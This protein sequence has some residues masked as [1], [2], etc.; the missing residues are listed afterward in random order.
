MKIIKFVG[1]SINGITKLYI[2]GIIESKKA[3]LIT[4]CNNDSNAL[5]RITDI[6]RQRYFL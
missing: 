5:E 1:V 6:K 4:L 3:E 2:D